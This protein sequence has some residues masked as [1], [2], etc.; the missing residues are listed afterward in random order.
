LTILVRETVLSELKGEENIANTAEIAIKIK[1]MK[2]KFF[3][4]GFIINY[5]SIKKSINQF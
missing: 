2:I 4:K 3:N 5:F 1:T